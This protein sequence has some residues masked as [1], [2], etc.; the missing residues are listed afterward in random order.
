M[1]KVAP[2]ITFLVSSI[3][4][5]LVTRFGLVPEYILPAPSQV[6]LT[7]I[8]EFHTLLAAFLQTLTAT[9]ISLII[10]LFVGVVSASLMT[11][12]KPIK[13]FFMPYMVFFQ[14]VPIVAIAPMLVVWFGFGTPTVIASSFI[15]S[16]F[17]LIVNTF[18][19]L[20]RVNPSLI[21][22]FKLYQASQLQ[23]F[24]KLRLPSAIPAILNGLKIATGLAV[25]GAVVGEFIAGTGLGSIIDAAR[26]QQKI[27]LVFASIL[28][29]SLLGLILIKFI[30]LFSNIFLAKWKEL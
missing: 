10:S 28:A 23:V 17:P 3:L 30:D 14:T 7:L 20:S 9:L 21:D 2:L 19:G 6:I 4:L 29:T 8:A 12:S 15:V 11:L 1:S 27:D 18:D 26:T 5:E 22:L 13:D 16:V 24:F 25:I